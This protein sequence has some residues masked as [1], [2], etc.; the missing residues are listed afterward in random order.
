MMIT[1]LLTPA[2]EKADLTAAQIR[3]Q[4]VNHLIPA[5]NI[6]RFVFAAQT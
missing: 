6:S 4:Q 3:F 2:S 1:V 5:W